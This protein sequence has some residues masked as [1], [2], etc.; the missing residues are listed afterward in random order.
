MY[1]SRSKALPSYF[2][3][4]CK[5]YSGDHTIFCDRS[6][7]DSIPENRGGAVRFKDA[8]TPAPLIMA[9]LVGH[10]DGGFYRRDFFSNDRQAHSFSIQLYIYVLRDKNLMLLC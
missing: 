3:D 10:E 5:A 1:V 8:R 2:A 9:W 7:F 4:N 6:L